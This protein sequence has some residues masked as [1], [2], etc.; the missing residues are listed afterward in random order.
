MNRGRPGS[1]GG[2]L[3]F[4]DDRLDAL[5]AGALLV[6]FDMNGFIVDDEALQL[7]AVRDALAGLGATIDE[8]FWIERCVGHRATD[9][10]PRILRR[11]GIDYTEGDV[12]RL[13]ERKNLLYRDRLMRDPASLL[14]PGV[15]EIIDALGRCGRTLALATSAHAV[16]ARIIL[17]D[18]GIGIMDRFAHVVTGEEVEKGKPDPEIY[19]LLSTRAGVEPGECLVFEDSGLGVEAAH[20]AGMT[21]LAVPNRFTRSQDFDG[22]AFILSDVTRQAKII[23][24]EG[25]SQC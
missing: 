22:A 2:N 25:Y 6:A 16:E 11:E 12:H 23:G 13:V 7:D 1:R 8:E 4:V 18:E 20:R 24:P 14:R 19:A 21:C 5:V 17:G 15:I 10:F 9:F 3:Y